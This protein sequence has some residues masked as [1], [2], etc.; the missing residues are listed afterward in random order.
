MPRNSAAHVECLSLSVYCLEFSDLRGGA[1]IAM[2]AQAQTLAYGKIICWTIA[3][4][5]CPNLGQKFVT[6]VGA[7]IALAALALACV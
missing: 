1:P 6:R 4:F 3:T 7:R 5:L 2:G